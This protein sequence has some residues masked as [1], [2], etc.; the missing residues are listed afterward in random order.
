MILSSNSKNL[1]RLRRCQFLRP[2][3]DAELV[4]HRIKVKRL[5]KYGCELNAGQ[6]RLLKPTRITGVSLAT[7]GELKVNLNMKFV[8]G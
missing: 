8:F 3:S 2:R 4:P 6:R 1:S 7:A 5:K